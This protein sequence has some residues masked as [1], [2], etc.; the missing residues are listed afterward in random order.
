MK[1]PRCESTDFY[2]DTIFQ[3]SLSR[4]VHNGVALDADSDYE[5]EEIYEHILV[6]Q[7]CPEIRFE[8]DRQ[9][10]EDNV[11]E[12]DVDGYIVKFRM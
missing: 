2:L 3:G 1:C 12:V 6:C 10:D 7:D 4:P 9:S 8:T 11:V 5:I